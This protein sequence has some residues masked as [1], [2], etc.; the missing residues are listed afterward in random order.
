M[1]KIILQAAA[2]AAVVFVLAA[3]SLSVW[4]S[5]H[6]DS[7]PNEAHGSQSAEAKDHLGRD[8][9]G[10]L[11]RTTEDPVAFF[12]L[13]LTLFTGVLAAFTVWLALSTKDLRDFAEEQARDMKESISVARDA[14]LAAQRSTELAEKSL[15]AANRPW[16]KVDIA[17]GGPIFYN[18]NGANMTLR[19]DKADCCYIRGISDGI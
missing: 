14:S 5:F 11:D 17:V 9:K 4:R 12:T 3:I 10:F 13:W 15:V 18:V 8:E 16:I 6:V 7:P 2:I 19:V 1:A